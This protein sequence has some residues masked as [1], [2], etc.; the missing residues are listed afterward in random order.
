MCMKIKGQQS[1]VHRFVGPFVSVASWQRGLMRL[2]YDQVNLLRIGSVRSIRTLA[3]TINNAPSVVRATSGAIFLGLAKKT[4]F[5]PIVILALTP[6]ESKGQ[7]DLSQL[8]NRNG[9]SWEVRQEID[10]EIPL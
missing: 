5:S 10:S 4:R 9:Q 2:T 3:A 6:K 1:N 8:R 7:N